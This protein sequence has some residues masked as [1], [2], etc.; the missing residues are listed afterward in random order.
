MKGVDTIARIRREFFVWGKTP[1]KEIVRELYVSRNTVRKVLRSG[2]TEFTYAREVQ[3]PPKLG[4]WK[5]ELDRLLAANEAKPA[6][7][8]LTLIRVFEALRAPRPRGRCTTRRAATPVGGMPGDEAVDRGLCAADLRAARR[9]SLTGSHEV[10]L[11][12]GTTVIVKVAHVRL[13]SRML[14]VRAYLRETQEM[15]FD[16]HDRAFAFFKGACTRGIYDNMKTAVETIFAGKGPSYNRRF[17]Q[18]CSHFLVDP[19]ACTPASGWEK[20]R[21]KT[22]SACARALLHAPPPSEKLRRAERLADGSGDRLRQGASASRV[23][24]PDD[25]ASVR[26]GTRQPGPYPDGS[27]GSMPCPRRCRRPAS[28]ASTTTA[29]RWRR[30]AVGRPVD[31][32]MWSGSRSSPKR[33]RSAS[34]PAGS[35]ATG[36]SAIRGTTSPSLP[37]SWSP[38]QRRA[39]TTGCC[40]LGWSGST[41][42][43]SVLPP[44]A[45]ASSS[46]FSPP[47]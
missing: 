24:G 28:C 32:P 17:L 2:V 18:M 43:S 21:W 11:I 27:T 42:S 7:E 8:R 15:V 46:T 38:A 41:A 20:G 13:Y 1:I 29:T 4:R 31:P 5:A 37:V 19:V 16:A 22:R 40:P 44:M 34:I 9:T 10:V 25:L 47:S 39:S 30:A 26:G 33:A 14:F 12:N 6:R 3:P 23:Q 36:R 35:G 45:T